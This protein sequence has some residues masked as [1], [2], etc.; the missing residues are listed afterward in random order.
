MASQ[1]AFSL[2]Q[3]REY[4]RKRQ[5]SLCIDNPGTEV[6]FICR[7]NNGWVPTGCAAL[8]RM[9]VPGKTVV[10]IGFK[11]V[12]GG[13]ECNGRCWFEPLD[14]ATYTDFRYLRIEPI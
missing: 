13:P 5:R 3:I 6:D 12:E 14:R 2:D 1:G 10:E 9:A 11:C 8:I 4:C 7:H